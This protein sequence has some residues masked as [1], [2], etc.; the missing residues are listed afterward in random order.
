VIKAYPE[1]KVIYC[2]DRFPLGDSGFRG[3]VRERLARREHRDLQGSFSDN[4]RATTE[5]EIQAFLKVV[6][7]NGKDF[8]AHI[9]CARCRTHARF[10]L[11]GDTSLE[12]LRPKYNHPRLSE[13]SEYSTSHRIAKHKR[14]ILSV[15]FARMNSRTQTL[16]CPSA[17]G[18]ADSELC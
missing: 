3:T 18:Q 6:S 4:D 8:G 14:Q 1:I 11:C 16:S 17:R 7:M 5:A 9:V 10:C 2:R 15:V 13:A 12:D